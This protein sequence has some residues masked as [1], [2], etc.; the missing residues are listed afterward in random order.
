MVMEP[1][2][3]EKEGFLSVERGQLVEALDTSQANWL[4]L[5]LPQSPGGMEVEGFLPSRCL[6]PAKRGVLWRGGYVEYQTLHE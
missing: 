3:T 5:A 6:A 4:V 2:S 1:F